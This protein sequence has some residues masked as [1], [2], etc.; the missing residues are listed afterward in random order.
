MENLLKMTN[1]VYEVYVCKYDGVV[2]YVGQGKCGRHKH[3]ASGCSH[4]YGLNELHF[5]GDKSKLEVS[6]SVVANKE[7]ALEKESGLIKRYQPK[8]NKVGVNDDR[9]DKAQVRSLFRTDFLNLLKEK[10]VTQGKKVLIKEIFNEFMKYHN[11]S[12]LL[13]EGLAIRGHGKYKTAGLLKM[14]SAISN[15]KNGQTSSKSAHVI[16]IDLLIE[17]Y[18]KHYDVEGIVHFV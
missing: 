16:F 12:M 17:C 5:K 9:Y 8:F 18:Q 13:E 10:Q 3:C 7:I 4:V 15:I 11:H 14:S 6:V 2:V 1:G